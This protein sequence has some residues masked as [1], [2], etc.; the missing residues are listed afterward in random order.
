MPC[1]VSPTRLA[2]GGLEWAWA[3]P[4]PPA[5]MPYS[6]PHPREGPPG[7]PIRAALPSAT[8]PHPASRWKYPFTLHPRRA[9][10]TQVQQHGLHGRVLLHHQVALYAQTVYNGEHLLRKVQWPLCGEATPPSPGLH[11]L[12]PPRTS[13]QTHVTYTAR[14]PLASWQGSIMITLPV[15]QPLAC[16]T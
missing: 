9:P 6:T 13:T 1:L 5:L 3:I 10:L 16:P 7:S 11:S 4:P 14:H 12:I 2:R 15:S 8:R